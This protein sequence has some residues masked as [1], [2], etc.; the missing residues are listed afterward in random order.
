MPQAPQI[1]WHE[2][3]S[4]FR[5]PEIPFLF[6]EWIF[7]NKLE[8][9][10]GKSVL[11]C[12]CGGGQHTALMAPFANKIVAVDL[13]TIDLAKDLNRDAQNI[14]FRQENILDMN[15]G[16]EFDIVL[17]IGVIHHTDHPEKAVENLKRH[18]SRGGRIILWV[19]SQKG[20]FLMKHL[21]EP[22][23][24]LIFKKLSRRNLKF[25][26]QG[27]TLLLYVPVYSLYLFPLPFLPYFGYFKNFRRLPF[28]RNTLNIFDKLNAPQVDFISKKRIQTWFSEAEFKDIHVSP[29]VGVSW[30]ISATR[31]I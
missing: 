16:E 14:V 3:W 20:N 25:F 9:F 28:Y 5:K 11:E 30:R 4:L 1:E 13:N 8:D 12:G 17:S 24:R 15:L 7:P 22:A 2:Q 29:Y 31:K 18:L 10:R 21:V 26:S 27:I 19:Y 23:R 6:E